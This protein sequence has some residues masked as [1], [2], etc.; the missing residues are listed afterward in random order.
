MRLYID[1]IN[2]YLVW[3]SEKNNDQSLLPDQY[4]GENVSQE[5]IDIRKAKVWKNIVELCYNKD[6]GIYWFTKFILGDMTY[7]GYPTIVR[8]N[9]LWWEWN[10]LIKK[11][12]HL[13]IRASRQHGKAQPYSAKVLTPKGWTTMGKLNIG[14]EV[15]SEKGLPTIVSNIF[16]QGKKDVYKITF[17]DGSTTECE[18]N[19]L[20]KVKRSG[21]KKWKVK[22]LK[23]II[24]EK[25]MNPSSDNAYRIPLTKPVQFKKVKHYIDPYIFGCLLG[26]GGLTNS[27][28]MFTTSDKCILKS[29]QK[30]MEQLSIIPSGKYG[31]RIK[32]KISNH[33]SPLL[34]ELKKLKLYGKHSKDKFIPK[35]YLFDSVENRI[36]LLRGLMDTD[37]G[38]YDT[39]IIEYYSV[40]KKLCEGVVELVQ[41]L[42]GKARIDI[43]NGKYNG[44]N[45]KSFRVKIWLQDINPFSIKRKADKFYKIKYK[46]YR[47]IKKIKKVRKENCRCIMVDD[48]THTYITNNY[49]VTHNTTFWSIIQPLYRASLFEYYNVLIESASEDQSIRIMTQIVR[50]IENNEFLLSKKSKSARWST[51]DIS[52]NGGMIQGKG[53]GSEIRGG[54]FDY[55][56]CDDVLRSDNK[57]SD[58]DIEKF[59]IEELEPMI[60]VRRGQI[61]VVGT[62]QSDT[63]IFSVIDERIEEDPDCGWVSKVYP[64]IIDWGEKQLLTP[65]RFTWQQLMSKKKIMGRLKF[66]KEFLCKT[67]SSGSQLFP[68]EVRKTAMDKGKN[69]VV[70]SQAKTKYDKN[71]DYFIGID[72]ARSGKASGDYTV[73][74]VLAFNPQTQEKRVVWMWRKKGLKT[75]E[76]VK[77]IAE[78]SSNFIHPTI[79]VEQ[80]N[81]GQDFIDMMVDDYNLNVESFTTTK[82]SKYEDLIRYLIN[83]FENEKIIL[84]TGNEESKKMTKKIDFELDRFVVEKTK[85]GNEVYKGSG[86][87]HDDITIALALANR[88]TQVYGSKPFARTI[89]QKKTSTLERFAKSNDVFEIMSYGW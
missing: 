75:S 28:C 64:A 73:V 72:C 16:E 9:N 60:L 18:L 43:K 59:V 31:Y 10:K 5:R 58:E 21:A 55:I 48:D 51:T 88:C 87:S 84:P 46:P 3:L 53:V 69:F 89:D 22:S 4:L 74:L 6:T 50:L 44:E 57:L 79:L 37:G 70:Y 61:V 39:C 82:G 2:D 76:Q 38:I 52:Y 33:K 26:D 11:S 1:M 40:S 80:N 35:E 85:A 27:S 62:P 17:T 24:D 56:S 63:D 8:F 41:S 29:F 68:Y 71:I 42:G 34:T 47:I 25:G 14:D 78:I 86:R 81:M 12:D 30:N 23:E 15:M 54:T 45:H 67:Y 49:I 77:Q 13:S 65:D 7:A 66:E 20:W 36:K 19:H 32:D 83:A